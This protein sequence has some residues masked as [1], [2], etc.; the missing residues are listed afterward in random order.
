M[1]GIYNAVKLK[2]KGM[3]K[4]VVLYK[5]EFVDEHILFKF[6]IIK[7]NNDS[8]LIIQFDYNSDISFDEDIVTGS[9]VELLILDEYT[10]KWEVIV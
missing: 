5:G 9:K 10:A 6:I 7:L 3:D 2:N 8:G 4:G 1:A